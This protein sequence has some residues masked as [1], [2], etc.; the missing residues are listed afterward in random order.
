MG[1]IIVLMGL[2]MKG[3]GSAVI[4][5]ALER[6]FLQKVGATLASGKKVR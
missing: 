6:T 1:S 5:M 4:S 2:A 3:I